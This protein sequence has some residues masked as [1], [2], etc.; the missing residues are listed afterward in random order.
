LCWNEL[1]NKW[2]TQYTW[3]PEFSENVDNIFYTFANQISHPKASNVLYKHGFAGTV[4]LAGNIRPT[5]W[6]D[7][8]YPFEFEFIVIGVPGIQKIFNN[9]KI[10]SNSVAPKAFYYEIVGEGYDWKDTKAIIYPFIQPADYSTYLTNNPNQ[11]KLP[12]ILTQ[13]TDLNDQLSFYRDRQSLVVPFNSSILRDLTIRQQAKTKEYL[14]DIYQG[15]ADIKKY[16]RLQGNMQYVEDAWDVQ[17]QPISF[18]YVY[19]KQGILTFTQTDEIKIR[20]K[21]DGTEY[22]IINFLRTLFTISYA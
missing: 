8:Q 17:I 14:I 1:T 13:P 5:Y 6:Y 18:K 12:Y 11:K 22:A 20:V 15:A 10:I 7:T 4:D 3:F 16:G 2:T 21:Y 9:L 19:L